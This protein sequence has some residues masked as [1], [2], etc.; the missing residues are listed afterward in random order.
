M[1]WTSE[2]VWWFEEGK[3]RR[4]EDGLGVGIGKKERTMTCHKGVL[5]LTMCDTYTKMREQGV[6]IQL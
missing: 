6:L 4:V 1:M 3:G 5:A 2:E